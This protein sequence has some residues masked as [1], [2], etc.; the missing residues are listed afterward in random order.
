M[1]WLHYSAT[2][3][4]RCRSCCGVCAAAVSSCCNCRWHHEIALGSTTES[5]LHSTV[6]YLPPLATH[7]LSRRPRCPA[8]L[9][10]PLSPAFPCRCGPIWRTGTQ[11]C[12]SPRVSRCSH[13][14]WVKV[15][16]MQP[17]FVAFTCMI[18]ARSVDW[19]PGPLWPVLPLLGAQPPMHRSCPH[20]CSPQDAAGD[21]VRLVRVMPNTPCL[22]GETAAAM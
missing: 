16:R 22:V 1:P 7:P 4:C 10:S 21:G 5:N 6:L 20:L 17:C 9:S 2:H 13:S 8:A 11:L 18:Q 15:W 12:P 14:R 3:A 19:T